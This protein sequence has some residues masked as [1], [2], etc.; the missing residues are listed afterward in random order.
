MGAEIEAEALELHL[1]AM[2]SRPP[3]FYWSPEMVRVV[4]SAQK[5][6]ADGLQVY[7]TLDAGPNVHL[8][9]EGKDAAQVESL[10]R[11]VQG[12]LQVYVNTPGN[13]AHL[14]DQHLF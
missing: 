3:I 8:I 7:F 10:A 12:V 11:G 14:S 6:R 13:G 9:C 5:W 1:I 2:T 4:Q